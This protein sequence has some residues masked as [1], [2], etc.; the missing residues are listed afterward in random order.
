MQKD[1]VSF[2]PRPLPE[3][4]IARITDDPAFAYQSP[5]RESQSLADRIKSWLRRQIASMLSTPA[6]RTVWEIGL[7]IAF[8]VL[9][10]LL[11]N[12]YMK[13][14]SGS[15]FLRSHTLTPLA[16]T[17]N[18]SKNHRRD[19]EALIQRAIE[20]GR[21]RDAIRHL[22]RRALRQL[23]QGGHIQWKRNKTNHDYLYEI[24][25]E[26][27]R[28]IFRDLTHYYEHAEYGN[29]SIDEENF[30][31]AYGRF[32]KMETLLRSSS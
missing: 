17:T 16:F 3:K 30:E 29:F 22:Y 25:R 15:L 12:Q 18:R 8:I 28:R 20:D 6:A 14:H 7:Y 26:S 13:R 31:K 32:K 21:F 24:Q 23:Q 10:V 11:I 9:I 4:K 27:L 19:D 2:D 1:T 5:P